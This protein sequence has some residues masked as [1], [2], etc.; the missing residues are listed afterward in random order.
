MRKI[1]WVAW[2]DVCR[3]REC[4][5]LGIRNLGAFNLALLGKW[6]WRCKVEVN[7][8][9]RRVLVARYGSLGVAGGLRGRNSSRWWRDIN[10]LDRAG[11]GLTDDWLRNNLE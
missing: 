2:E 9:W 4:G 10:S 5:G 7:M 1:C 8:L 3:Q 6:V 11:S